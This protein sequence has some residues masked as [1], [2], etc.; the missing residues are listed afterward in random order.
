[1]RT[2]ILFLVV[3]LVGCGK[4][5]VPPTPPTPNVGGEFI[6]RGKGKTMLEVKVEAGSK[7]S[8]DEI[9]RQ[10]GLTVQMVDSFQK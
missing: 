10:L 9:K 7:L 4:A 3:V 8:L 2:F 6:L 5:P 1:M